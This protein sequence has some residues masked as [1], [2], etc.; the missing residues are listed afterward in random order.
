M[1]FNISQVKWSRIIISVIG[2]VLLSYLVTA[3]IITGYAFVLAFKAR[4][5]P[6][7]FLISQFAGRISIITVYIC[8]L[9]FLFPATL[10]ANRKLL[11]ANMVHGLIIGILLIIVDIPLTYLFG[12]HLRLLDLI[13]YLLIL[14]VGWVGDRFCR[15]RILK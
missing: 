6:D 11:P 4:G 1:P 14:G 3:L 13:G 9:I 7:Q 10:W 2:V 15:S 5:A 12:Q 8:Y